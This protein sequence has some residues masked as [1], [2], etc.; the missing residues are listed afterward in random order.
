MKG[1]VRL[2]LKPYSKLML[3][4]NIRALYQSEIFERFSV[5]LRSG[6]VFSVETRDHIWVTPT[7]VVHLVEGNNHR[8]FDFHQIDHINWNEK[9]P[10]ENL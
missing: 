5:V 8:L 7:G 9:E 10:S 4:E 3:P 1:S 6:R 2:K